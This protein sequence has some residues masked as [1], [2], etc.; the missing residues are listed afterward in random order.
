M[1]KMITESQARKILNDSLL[2]VLVNARSL[3]LSLETQ[4]ALGN[5]VIGIQDNY[6]ELISLTAKDVK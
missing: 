5:V 6:K 2:M 1:E 4:I 3:E